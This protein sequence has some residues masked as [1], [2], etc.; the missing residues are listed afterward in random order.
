MSE[1][2]SYPNHQDPGQE[3]PI[4]QPP[5]YPAQLPSPQSSDGQSLVE[6][7]P[8]IRTSDGSWGI[9]PAG[10]GYAGDPGFAV[11]HPSFVGS[12]PES[13][14][15]SDILR[16]ESRMNPSEHAAIPS[17]ALTSVCVWHQS[18]R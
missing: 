16:N 8:S 1:E 2:R 5:I 18:V 15:V 7:A 13:R 3:Y 11:A 6:H 17:H 9:I 10:A 12:L 14:S 4:G